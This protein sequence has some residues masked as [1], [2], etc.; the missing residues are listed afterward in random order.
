MDSTIH[1]F[2]NHTKVSMKVPGLVRACT[3]V[4][5]SQRTS[6]S[7]QA[8]WISPAIHMADHVA[9]VSHAGDSQLGKFHRRPIQ[10]A[11]V[12]S[13]HLETKYRRSHLQH[14]IIPRPS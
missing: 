9:L 2:F 3:N 10:H 8:G 12:H 1:S 7:I 4:S 6:Q 14:V 13:P 5:D 11:L